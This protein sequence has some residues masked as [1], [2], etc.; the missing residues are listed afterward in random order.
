VVEQVATVFGGT[1]FL[2]RRVVRALAKAG[3]QVRIAARHPSTRDF[4]DL[5]SQLVP[6][7]VDLRDEQAVAEAVK[8]AAAVVNAVSLYVEKGDLTFQ[9]VHVQGAERLARCAKAA[10]VERFVHVSG[11]GVDANSPSAFVRARA[12]GEE[13]VRNAFEQATIVRPSVM[14]ACGESFLKALEDVT[15]LPVVPLFGRGDTRLQPA[16]VD[17]V[18]NAIAYLLQA[19]APRGMV[20]ELGGGKVYTYREAVQEVAAHLGRKRWLLRVPFPL[21]HGIVAILSA[22]PN[23]PL[24]R[25]QLV[26]M[27]SDNIVAKGANTF[28]TLGIQPRS[29]EE[30]L[31]DC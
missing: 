24:T 17:D 25:D 21:W 15:R 11:I 26:L 31:E 30:V 22:L 23:P 2:G 29:L 12:R 7:T 20:F 28:S 5:Q 1:G 10:G 4:P 19:G 27:K 3:D 13:V 9:V 16:W 8:G 14:F 18:A 6:V